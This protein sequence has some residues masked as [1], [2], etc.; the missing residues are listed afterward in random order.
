MGDNAVASN[1]TF[2]SFPATYDLTTVTYIPCNAP[3]DP[4][5]CYSAGSS[6]TTT[7]AD[8]PG[9][10]Y[11]SETAVMVYDGNNT[12]SSTTFSYSPRVSYTRRQP[13]LQ[14]IIHAQM[15]TGKPA[16]GWGNCYTE[17]DPGLLP[18]DPFALVRLL[19]VPPVYVDHNSTVNGKP[20]R[21]FSFTV[22]VTA[23]SAAD[24]LS[25]S[26]NATLAWPIGTTLVVLD[27][28]DDI[29]THFPLRM[30]AATAFD[31]WG[32]PTI[33]DI[34]SFSPDPYP[35]TAWPG[36][37]SLDSNTCPPSLMVRSG[38]ELYPKPFVQQSNTLPAGVTVVNQTGIALSNS[39][40][41]G[42]HL[43]SCPGADF[44]ISSAMSLSLSVCPSGAVGFDA[45]GH[46][47]WITGTVS[48]DYFPPNSIQAAGCI[49]LGPGYASWP[50]KAQEGCTHVMSKEKCKKVV[51]SID[52]CAVGRSNPTAI[53]AYASVGATLFDIGC[54][55]LFYPSSHRVSV[56][57][58]LKLSLGPIHLDK[59]ELFDTSFSTRV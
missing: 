36:P 37:A 52:V 17:A 7:N 2:P 25:D 40:A 45:S 59:I 32:P 20:A 4:T 43:L 42:R 51:P 19:K 24:V 3:T 15:L 6:F 18:T 50:N 16:G 31:N 21:H 34:T 48:L 27:Y 22:K 44:S 14:N 56:T 1:V 11:F 39:S 23:A 58:D 28:Y 54:T 5:W 12:L 13:A 10:Y 30:V 57:A 47:G 9:Q 49:E 55:A 46:Q 8:F 33:V 38:D 53:G 29:Y 35:N 41:A 26:P